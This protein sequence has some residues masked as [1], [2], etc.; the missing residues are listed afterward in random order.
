MTTRTYGSRYGELG[1]TYVSAADIA[2]LMRRDIK[3]AVG[4]G[5]LPG[6]VGNYSVRVQNYAGGRSIDVEARDLQG[7]WQ[8]CDGTVPGTETVYPDGS[9]TAQAC[10]NYVHSETHPGSHDN[11]H[12]V[13]TAEGRRIE[14]VLAEIHAAYNHD[15]SDSMTDYY[16]VNYY[17]HARIEY[18]DQAAFRA[19]ERDRKLARLAALD[20]TRKATPAGIEIDRDL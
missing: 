9:R 8:E 5:K 2:K 20:R 4:E 15:G 17:G 18:E 13:L 1:G 14:K 7:L 16:D 11:T 3:T 19:R 12:R 10:P 6:R